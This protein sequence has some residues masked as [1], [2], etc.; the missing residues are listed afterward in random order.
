MITLSLC[1]GLTKKTIKVKKKYLLRLN[2][3]LK[4]ELKHIQASKVCMRTLKIVSNYYRFIV[5][6]TL[7]PFSILSCV[8]FHPSYTDSYMK[9][10]K[11]AKI[12]NQCNHAPHL[13]QDTNEK[14]TTSQQYITNESQEVSPFPAGDHKAS[15]NRRA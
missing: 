1:L 7:P 6:C 4:K 3:E 11:R 15:T 9:V 2:K 5:L 10:R 13:T 8:W 12:K 14:V